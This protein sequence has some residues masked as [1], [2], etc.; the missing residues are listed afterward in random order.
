MSRTARCK[1]SYCVTAGLLLLAGC[2]KDP[3]P[4]ARGALAAAAPVAQVDDARLKAADREPGQWF[5]PGRDGAGTY[6]SPLELINEQNVPRLGFAWAYALGTKR[7][8]ESTP[9]VV[10]GVLYASG[11]WGRVYA[12]DAASGRELWTYDPQVSGRYGRA[13]CCDAVNR[14]LAVWK[15]RV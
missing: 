15:G 5:T 1:F 9:V 7:G 11:N 4:A 2:G 3:V 12:L 10:D 14:G 13:A 6:Y 8:Q